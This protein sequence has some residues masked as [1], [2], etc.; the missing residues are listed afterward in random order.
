[1]DN[2]GEKGVR[3]GRKKGFPDRTKDEMA[4]ST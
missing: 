1:M 2:L 3:K 4:I